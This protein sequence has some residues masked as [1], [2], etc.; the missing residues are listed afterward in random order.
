MSDEATQTPAGEPEPEPG[1]ETGPLP[2][3]PGLLSKWEKWL[4]SAPLIREADDA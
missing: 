2:E 4:L 3:P 1:L